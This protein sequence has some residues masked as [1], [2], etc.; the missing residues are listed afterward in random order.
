MGART[1]TNIPLAPKSPT[2]PKNKKD[3]MYKM[4]V[5]KIEL[6]RT[7]QAV[8]IA[9]EYGKTSLSRLLKIKKISMIKAYLKT[10]K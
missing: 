4:E 10:V 5:V 1:S 6:P 9:E 2:S 8:K 3:N 7:R